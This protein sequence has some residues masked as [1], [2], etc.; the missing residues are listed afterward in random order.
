MAELQIEE[1]NAGK[2]K[3]CKAGDF[4]SMHYTGWLTNGK[5]FDSSIDRNEPFDFKLGVGQVIPGWDQG[6]EGMEIGEKR[7]LTIPSKLAY[8]EMG[9][10]PIPPSATIIFEVELLAIK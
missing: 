10:G 7:K 8:G 4:I 1:L 9:T 2:G 5:K 6:I 3:S